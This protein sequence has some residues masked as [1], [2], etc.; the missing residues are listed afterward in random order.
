M[1]HVR[2]FH[3]ISKNGADLLTC[4]DLDV[5]DQDRGHYRSKDQHRFF[6]NNS[7]VIESR[8]KIRM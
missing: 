5:E 2:L 3:K 4:S 8:D 6:A 7:E 1:D